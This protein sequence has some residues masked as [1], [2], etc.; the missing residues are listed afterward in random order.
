MQGIVYVV[1]SS[2]LRN[3]FAALDKADRYE[4]FSDPGL[5]GFVDRQIDTCLSESD[6]EFEVEKAS[7]TNRPYSSGQMVSLAAEN[8]TASF[9]CAFSPRGGRASQALL[10]Q[11]PV[12]AFESGD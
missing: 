3:L 8:A 4:S 11:Y 12:S 7:Y 5:S 6:S 2:I 9:K 1:K 10:H